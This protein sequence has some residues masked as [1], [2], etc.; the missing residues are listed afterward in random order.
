MVDTDELRVEHRY[1]P[2]GVVACIVPWN[3]P[4][5]LLHFKIS[6]ALLAGCTVVVKP[7]EF[8]PLSTLHIVQAYNK[9]LPV[10]VLNVITS[11]KR[12][13]GKYLASHPGID[14]VSFTGSTEVGKLILGDSASSLKRVTLELG[15]NDAMIVLSDVDPKKIAPHIVQASLF[16]GGQICLAAKRVFIHQDI[17]DQVSSEVVSL[18]KGIKCGNGLDRKTTCGP[19]NNA[20]Q[21]SK[22]RQFLVDAVKDGAEIISGSVPPELTPD[23][24]Y[25]F[26]PVVLKNV[27]E[28]SRIV[29]EEQFGPVVPLIP[30][31]SIDEVIKRA[32]NTTMGLGGSVWTNDIIQGE[33]IAVRLE[34]GTSW[35]NNHADIIGPDDAPF[36]GIKSS[37]VGLEGGHEG[38]LGFMNTHIIKIVKTSKI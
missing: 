6:E 15:G 30:F 21:Y 3:F 38:L 32:N 28:G 16:N 18:V 1:K 34:C 5:L 4:V 27:K 37:G 35:V 12:S 24:G 11:E 25:L 13:I 23:S 36:G 33:Q 19:L 26:P 17:F 9:V 29:D 7:S 31:G 14:K 22:V 20:Q 10:G 8:T 2:V